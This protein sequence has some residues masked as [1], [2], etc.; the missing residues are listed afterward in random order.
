MCSTI[1]R[2]VIKSACSAS[3]AWGSPIRIP[4]ADLRTTWQAMLWQ[5]SH[6]QSRGRWAWT[7]AQGQSSSEKR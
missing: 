6:I 5:A 2:A 4:G 1:K 3:A 7:L